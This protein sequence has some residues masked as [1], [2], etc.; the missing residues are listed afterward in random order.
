MTAASPLPRT[1]PRPRSGPLT[2]R[3]GFEVELLAPP[4]RSRADLADL[5]AER[6]G[7]LVRR[8]FHTDS[9]PSL[10]PGMDHFIH[11]TQGF[12]VED[13]DGRPLARLVDD[14]T[15]RHDLDPQ[16]PPRPGWYRI[17]S[18]EPRLM[19]LTHRLADP[20][21]PLHTVLDPLAEA[22]GVR[23]EH[24]DGVV[25]VDDGEGATVAM[26]AP[27]PGERERPCEVITPPI[28]H[29]H[30]A[31]LEELLAPARQLGFTVPAEAAVHLH[32][33][34]EPLRDVHT[35]ANLV[36]LFSAW[37][38]RLREAL[39]T[40]P[41]CRRLAPLP[42]AV[43]ELV[44]DGVPHR[45]PD[46]C[47]A[48]SGLGLTKFADVN[49]T[50]LVAPRAVKDTVEIRCL[51]GS[52]DADAVLARAELVES[53]LQRCRDPRPLPSPAPG[54]RVQDLLAW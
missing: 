5:V 11:L 31:R 21:A 52:I 46:L 36:R 18:D 45:W 22:F 3:I 10:V 1:E 38:G 54:A 37:R 27:L 13:A 41:R 43:V 42:T 40:N 34:A 8:F 14:I 23:A 29:D 12:A 32:V 15:I 4:G 20:L 51:P 48:V 6:S 17:I 53:L 33:D 19:R 16:A 39:G 2:E 44:R 9:E 7:G 25:R 47:A 26:G 35:F 49:L 24:V 50:A 30:R 28:D